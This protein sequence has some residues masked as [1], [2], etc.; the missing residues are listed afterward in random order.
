MSDVYENNDF[1]ED[2]N[3]PEGMIQVQGKGKKKIVTKKSKKV[4]SAEH[5][6]RIALNQIVRDAGKAGIPIL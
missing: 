4:E 3:I 1:I 5:N 6:L 2:N